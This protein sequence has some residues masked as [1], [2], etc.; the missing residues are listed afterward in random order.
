MYYKEKK[1]LYT[2]FRL[3][4]LANWS[5]LILFPRHHHN[6]IY[7]HKRSTLTVVAFIGVG[8][9]PLSQLFRGLF[10]SEKHNIGVRIVVAVSA[11]THRHLQCFCGIYA[12]AHFTVHCCGNKWKIFSQPQ[13]VK[14]V[15]AF[16]EKT[17][18]KWGNFHI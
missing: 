3:I 12:C 17:A 14:I 18:I 15:N 8:K 16:G 9:S 5:P 6:S 7:A 1:S 10:A 2:I 13:T 4:S 11:A